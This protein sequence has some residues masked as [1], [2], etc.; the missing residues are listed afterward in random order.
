MLNEN[1]ANKFKISTD[2]RLIGWNSIMSI[3][4]ILNQLE[5]LYGRPAGHKLLQN[6]AL[7]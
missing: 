5:L 2:P 7:S 6:D 4:V 1:I 3:Q